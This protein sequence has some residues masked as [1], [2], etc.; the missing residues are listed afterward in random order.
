MKNITWLF[1]LFLSLNC[2][3]QPAN[4]DCL[5]AT[6]VVPDGSCLLGESTVSATD[7]WS[8]A[9]GCQGGNPNDHQD[10]WYSFVATGTQ[11]DITATSSGSWSGDIEITLVDGNCSGIFT[12][13]D[14]SCGT[15]PQQL[16]Y[17]GLTIG[18]TYYYTISNGAGGTQ[19]TFDVCTE[20]TSPPAGCVDNDLCTSPEILIV[21]SG[22]Q[23]CVSDCNTGASPGPD[24]AGTNC[25]DMLNETVW[26]SVTT[27]ASDVTMDIDLSSAADLSDPH[28]TVYQ[29]SDCN[30]FTIVECIQGTGGSATSS[31][32]VITPSTTYI[33]GVSDASGDVGDFDFCVT[34]NV[35][36]SP[37]NT[38]SDLVVTGT[39]LGSPI[40]GPFLPGEVVSFCY[41]ITDWQTGASCNYL[42]GIVPTFGDCW[43]ASSFDVNGMPV[44]ITTSLSTAGTILD[45]GPGPPDPWNACIGETAGW[46]NWYNAGVVSYN[47]LLANTGTA[48]ALPDGT[49][50]PAGWFFTTNYDPFTGQCTPDPTDPN[51]SY[52]DNNFPFCDNTLDWNICFDL[53]AG[54]S[55]NCTS[56]A[57]DC[58]VSMQTYADGEIGIWNSVGC[59]GNIPQ[60]FNGTLNCCPIIT[61]LADQTACDSYTLPAISG[62]LLSGSEA[63]FTGSTGTGTSYFPGDVITSS[64][65]PLYIYDDIGS[66]SDEDTVNITINTTLVADTP[67]DVIACDGYVLPALSVGNYFSSTG[68]VGSI[69][70]GANIT[71]TQTIF[72]YAETGTTPNCT[73]ENSFTVT[74]NTTPIADTPTDVIACDGYVLPALS[75]GNYFS[76]TG[77]VGSIAVGAN[78]TSTQ[79]IFV[80]A[81]TSTTPNCTDENS[82]TVTINTTPVADAP[83]DV[84]A[85]DGYVL[86]A[87]SVGNYFSSTGGVGSIAVGANI[88][89]TQTIF[90]YAETST[91]PNCTDENSFTVTINT[92]PVAP[93]A[94]TD[95]TYCD[96]DV[97]SDLFAA[98]SGGNLT[99]YDDAGLSSVIGSGN[100]LTPLNTIGTIIYY[101]TETLNGCEGL[102]STVTITIN[103]MPTISSESS[104]DVTACGVTDG[105]IDIVAAGG[106]GSYTFSID[107]GTTFTNTTGSFTGLDVNSYQVVVDDGNCQVTGSLLVISGPGIPPAPTAGTNATYCDGDPIADLTANADASGDNNNLTWYDDAGL[108]NIV[109]T[110]GGTFTPSST[111]GTSTY[112]ITE[113]VAGCQS[114]SSQVTIIINPTPSAPNLTGGNTYCD[115]D[116]IS[117]LQA[118]AGGANSGAFYWFDDMALTNNVAS[119]PVFTP[120]TSVG[121]LIYYVVD[122][123]NGCVGPSSSVSLTIN[124]T[125][126]FTLTSS[127]P[128]TCLGT[129]GQLTISGLDPNTT[130]DIDYTDDGTPTGNV[131]YTSDLNGDI[132]ISGLDAGT[133]TSIVITLNGCP[134]NDLGPYLLSDPL[135]P[136]F[137]VSASDPT[138]C[139]GTD[140]QLVI[141]GLDPNTTYDVNLTDDGI[142]TGNIS[143]TSDLNGDIIISGLDAG[144]YTSIIVT[145]NNCST[146]DAGSYLLTDPPMPTYAVS[147]TDPTICAGTDGQ[148]VISG[149]DPNT[150]YDINLTDDGMPTGNVSYT[151]DLNGD[152]IITGLNAGIYTTITVTLNGC[153][154]LDPGSYG[155]VDPNAPSPVIISTLDPSGCGTLDAEILIGNLDP[156]TTY[157]LDYNFNG[158][159]I[160]TT[161]ITTNA[162]GEFL[163]NGLDEG[164]Y[165]AFTLTFAGCVGNDA[166]IYI[167]A[168]VIPTI[169]QPDGDSTYCEGQLINDLTAAANFGGTIN[170]YDDNSL[171]NLVGN[172]NTFTQISTTAG[173][174]TYYVTETLN[175]CEGPDSAITIVIV[176]QP[177]VTTSAD[178]SICNGDT[179]VI[180]IDSLSGGSQLTWSNGDTTMTSSVYPSS[181]AYFNVIVDDGLGCSATDSTLVTVNPSDDASFTL[182][183]FCEGDA[184]SATNIVT[185]G[186]D[187][188]FNPS[189]AD[190]AF[191]DSATAEITNGVGGTT[192]SIMYLTSG[193]CEDSTTQNVTVNIMPPTPIVGTDTSY[194]EGEVIEDLTATGTGG[195]INWYDDIALTNLIG[196]GTILPPAISTS[197]TYTFYV[198]E[199]NGNCTS[200]VDSVKVTINSNPVADFT[201]SPSSGVIPLDVV[202]SNLSTGSGLTFEW[203]LG[204]NTTSTVQDPIHTYTSISTFTAYLLVTDING[205]TDETSLDI[206]TTGVSV[207][208]IPNV[209]TPNGDGVNDELKVIYE[210]IESFSG[211][212]ANRWG[213]ILYDWKSIDTGWNGR[214]KGGLL[215]PEGTY[216]YVITATGSDQVE[217]NTKGSFH[218]GR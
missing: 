3:A 4:D 48:G 84:T 73:D 111:V 120:S 178:T 213:E 85:C 45:G 99:W 31:N 112:Y 10:V 131:S 168:P 96:G 1:I 132:I 197:G 211:F 214:T 156:N 139:T 39:S 103:A 144:T 24:F 8:G 60:V 217:Y 180:Q 46:W 53:V 169:L 129:D 127:D 189:V 138:L 130:Y 50:L 20:T 116:P 65:T 72:V 190:G 92:T 67:A 36:N 118:S 123:L 78:I 32:I 206:T 69:A 205:C 77:G 191:I 121:T 66:C 182:T 64:V 181:T 41:S 80:Y 63:Y 90:I 83:A 199:S 163:L 12:V 185:V 100:S 148:L 61:P 51:L 192:Y 21:T 7:T 54:P 172:G 15:S 94:G 159:P 157:D 75:V 23:T 89:S 93:T 104:T 200:E 27:G 141:S 76:S 174:Y 126:S 153:S 70:V 30:L 17:N 95:A 81:E 97:L 196:N 2:F 79:T 14:G 218:L 19:G 16:I 42:S 87:L 209:F 186:G 193:V 49:P 155:L 18:N 162:S 58:G 82:F 201:A 175:G 105:T 203:D 187:F 40:T 176:P 6:S 161:S 179:I 204:D 143:Y 165:D 43:D 188:F 171:T 11:A 47:N 38:T 210:N 59:V 212:I 207:F 110:G 88:T 33:I 62:T 91:T 154:T 128:T 134:A 135:A 57:T 170:W 56:G 122:S 133:Y 119:G 160:V 26:Y 158:N 109:Q 44:T 107:G 13:L 86:P 149:L 106:S 55:G 202:F 25:Y 108:T 98:G 37:C 101:V 166:G 215:A 140:G 35:D 194:C 137:S 68:G 145:L 177:F 74:I 150:T 113:T 167:L 136:T 102:A 216:F 117:D 5:N 28:F 208:V 173:A 147:A 34:V 142:S 195:A 146:A 184:N 198:N 22:V 114:P 29:T 164:T 152:I 115:G 52:G 125:P 71:S 124:P 183:D 151:S 9:V